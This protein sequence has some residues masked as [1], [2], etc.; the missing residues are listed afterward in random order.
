V[1]NEVLSLESVVIRVTYVAQE[2]LDDKR[3]VKSWNYDRGF[4]TF[5]KFKFSPSNEFAN[6]TY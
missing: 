2:V 4:V 6:D 3:F 5:Q 1:T